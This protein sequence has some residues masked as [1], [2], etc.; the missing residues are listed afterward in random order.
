MIK[1]KKS[2]EILALEVIKKTSKAVPLKARSKNRVG[3][4]IPWQILSRVSGVTDEDLKLVIPYIKE[5][6]LDDPRNMMKY[7]VDLYFAGFESINDGI[8]SVRNDL[9]SSTIS[10][11]KAITD[12]I[13]TINV[14]DDKNGLTK[15]YMDQITEVIADLEEKIRNYSYE[16]KCIDD[17]PRYKFFLQANFNKSKV[18]HNIAFTKAAIQAY[19]ESL[20]I[21]GI[22]SNE[23][24]NSQSDKSICNDYLDRKREFLRSIKWALLLAY[25][26]DKDN[27]FWDSE[28]KLQEIDNI[29]SMS[30]TIEQYLIANNSCEIDFENDIKY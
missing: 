19:I 11:A 13:K 6:G 20:Y 2:K 17:L 4:K 7:L 1:L 5:F 21:Y 30:D 10:R 18:K 27:K 12:N 23:R 14:F 8:A 22:L 24:I 26:F 9:L 3:S 15:K 28:S 25:D 16:I 29:K